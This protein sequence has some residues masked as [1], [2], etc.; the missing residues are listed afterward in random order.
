LDLGYWETRSSHLN[1][2]FLRDNLFYQEFS[3]QIISGI[4]LDK[5]E[6]VVRDVLHVAGTELFGKVEIYS[7]INSSYTVESQIDT[8]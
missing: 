1:D 2:Q 5:Y 3:Y 8:L 6:S 4:S 7:D